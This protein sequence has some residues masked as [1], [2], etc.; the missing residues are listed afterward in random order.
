MAQAKVADHLTVPFNVGRLEV[1]EEAAALTD[2][3][4]QPATTMMVLGVRLEVA[5]EVIDTLGENS[6]LHAG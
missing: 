6:D 1:L 5:R 3:L 2:H 4:Q